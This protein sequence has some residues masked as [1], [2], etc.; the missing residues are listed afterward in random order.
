[1]IYWALGPFMRS[2]TL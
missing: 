1:M 2:F